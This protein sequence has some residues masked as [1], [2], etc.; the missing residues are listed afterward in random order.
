MSMG[1][2]KSY[3]FGSMK[4]LAVRYKTRLGRRRVEAG[5]GGRV[6]CWGVHCSIGNLNRTLGDNVIKRDRHR[7]R[8]YSNAH[9]PAVI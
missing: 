6:Y 3:I 9:P 8:L 5:V 4:S 2:G 1:D 7:L